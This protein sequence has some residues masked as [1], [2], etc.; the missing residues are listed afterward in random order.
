[1]NQ[2]N[3]PSISVVVPVY[4]GEKSLGE[5]VER[6]KNVMQNIASK[7]ELIMVND[8]SKDES[9]KTIVELANK[10]N[11]VKGIDLTRN[12]GQHNAVITGIQ[13]AQ[14]EIIITMDDDLQH[15]PEEILKL[16]EKIED[17]YDVVYGTPSNPKHNVVKNF[18]SRFIKWIICLLMNNRDFLNITSFRAARASICEVFKGCNSYH[19]VIDPP[20]FWATDKIAA[21]YI[22]HDLRKYGKS[23]FTFR[24]LFSHSIKMITV[25]SILPLQIASL[26]GFLFMLFGTT[27]FTYVMWNYFVNN[28]VQGF[29]FI[30]ATVSL[31]SGIQLFCLGIIGAYLAPIHLRSIGK[32]MSMI[33]KT[34][35][36][37]SHTK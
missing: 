34:T 37:N 21:V 16:V 7:W 13:T 14:Y 4:N 15:P 25:Y 35:N 9:W 3:K 27:L 22:N 31:F 17:G 28:V 19:T 8:G 1:M 20:L 23:N 12:Y 24:K 32:P 36:N 11:F 10:N 30:A 6:V 29:T 26:L 2:Q 33:R 18:A 5:L